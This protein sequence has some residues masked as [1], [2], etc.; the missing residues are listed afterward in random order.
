MI[1]MTKKIL[2]VLSLILLSISSAMVCGQMMHTLLVLDMCNVP[3]DPKNFRTT[4]DPLPV[5]KG[6]KWDGMTHLH[7]AGSGQFSELALKKILQRLNGFNG[8]NVR[9]ITIIDLRQEPHGFLNGNAI[10]W[11][12][13]QNA[14]NAGK[15]SEQIED[16]QTH[17]LDKLA[18]WDVVTV[19]QILKKTSDAVIAKTKSIEFPV[20][21]VASEVELAQHFHVNYQRI[22]VEDFHAP[23]A[24][25]VDRF[26]QIANKLSPHEWIYF[27]CRAGVGRTTTFMAMYDMMRNAKQ[28]SFHDILARQAAIGGKDF[29]E[30]L[31]P[32]KWKYKF[33]VERSNFLKKFYEYAHDNNDN[34]QTSWTE[35]LVAHS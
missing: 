16:N 14:T 27:H 35:W 25:E 34:F 22:Y 26:I 32:G 21:R 28:V 30:K 15:T 11:Y 17:R 4:S 29:N 1:N 23:I 5:I 31:D 2:I 33:A 8:L 9:R 6:I 20:R 18:S 3:E 10:S 13:P 7:M 24:S 19:H 12:G